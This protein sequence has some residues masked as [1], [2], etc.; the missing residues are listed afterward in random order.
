MSEI[1]P[2]Q[3]V[4]EAMMLHLRRIHE[5]DPI[6]ASGLIGVRVLADPVALDKANIPRWELGDVTAMI[7]VLT[8]LNGI[9][10]DMGHGR[11]RVAAR[12][13]YGNELLGF[14]VIDTQ[15]PGEPSA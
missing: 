9:L 1:E 15:P 3:A 4:A 5:S 14:H 8:L 2:G 11:W 10:A 6:A 13:D 12:L 7:G